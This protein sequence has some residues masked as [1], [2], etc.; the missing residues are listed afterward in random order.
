MDIHGRTIGF[1]FTTGASI[2]L[3]SICPNGD[4]GKLKQL[5]TSKGKNTADALEI[6]IKI[7]A[8]LS[9]GFELSKKFEEPGYKPRP[10]T[11][12]EI[13]SLPVKTIHALQAVAM[14][15]LKDDSAT[16]IE[17]EEPKKE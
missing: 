17:L 11:V 14:K 12:E 7:I 1:K 9:E 2:A 15:Q 5:L 6:A 16:D 13:C 4:V 8:I 3:A 10:L